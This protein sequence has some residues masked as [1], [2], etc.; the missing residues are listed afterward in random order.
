ME[1]FWNQGDSAAVDRLMSPDA[2][3]HM[4]TGEV[5][6]PDGLKAFVEMWRSA[7][8][9]WCATTEELVAEGD[10]VVERW[11]ANGTHRGEL[12]GMPSTGA[13]VTVQGTVYYTIT[14]GRI[15]DFRGQFDLAALRRQLEVA[16]A[17]T[18]VAP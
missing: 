17:R 11:T 15:T 5:I 9:D 4:P 12:N 8:P 10:R 2:T 14:D 1:E 16:T 7:F 3:I 18:P 13:A 6:G